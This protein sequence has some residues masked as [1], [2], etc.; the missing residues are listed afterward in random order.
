MMKD[1]N[2]KQINSDYVKT[3]GGRIRGFRRKAGL[4]QIELAKKTVHLALSHL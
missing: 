4:T 2:V 3:I 1:H